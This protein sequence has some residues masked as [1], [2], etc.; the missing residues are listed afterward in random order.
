MQDTRSH[1]T[2][3]ACKDMNKNHFHVLSLEKRLII[4]A[5]IT[6]GCFCGPLPPSLC[7][8]KVHM[9]S[10]CRVLDRILFPRAFP[11]AD[12]TGEIELLCICVVV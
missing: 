6:L 9:A 4:I 8:S 7:L 12:I 2:E 10:L 5:N 3:F 1:I 11:S